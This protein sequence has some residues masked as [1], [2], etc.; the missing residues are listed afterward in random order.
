MIIKS[1]IIIIQ[2]L[3]KN[4]PTENEINIKNKMRKKQLHATVKQFFSQ[5]RTKEFQRNNLNR[6]ESIIKGRN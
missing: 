4:T 6:I 5:V 2:L 3:Q 1:V